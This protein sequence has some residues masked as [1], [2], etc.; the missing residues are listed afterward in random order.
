MNR[1]LKHWSIKSNY[2]E[3]IMPS[4]YWLTRYGVLRLPVIYAVA[5]L[6]AI[7]QIIPLIGAN[8]L[9]P[10]GIFLQRVGAPRIAQ[11]RLPRLPSIF[12]FSF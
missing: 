8:G 9:L 2:H 1:V 3:Q 5:F 10:V 4:T 12:W 11:R 7:N 6:V